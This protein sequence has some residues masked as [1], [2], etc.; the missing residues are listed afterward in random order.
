MEYLQGVAKTSRKRFKRSTH[1]IEAAL[2]ITYVGHEGHKGPV[3]CVESSEDC[4]WLCTGGED[5][6]VRVWHFDLRLQCYRLYACLQ[7]GAVV[8]SVSFIGNVGPV[9]SVTEK[10]F[11]HVWSLHAHPNEQSTLQVSNGEP[12]TDSCAWLSEASPALARQPPQKQR[13][14]LMPPLSRASAMVVWA[15]CSYGRQA[16]VVEVYAEGSDRVND[17][18]NHFFEEKCI[19]LHDTNVERVKHIPRDKKDEHTTIVTSVPNYI[20]LWNMHGELCDKLTSPDSS[21]PITCFTVSPVNND[22]DRTLWIIAGAG[23][24]QPGKV[25]LWA[26]WHGRLVDLN[27]Q[28]VSHKTSPAPIA[29]YEIPDGIV[30][31]AI[32]PDGVF[33]VVV[34]PH[35]GMDIVEIK[36]RDPSEAISPNHPGCKMRQQGR[37]T[38]Q[39]Y[40]AINDRHRDIVAKRDSHSNDAV[41][42]V[43]Y[44]DGSCQLW[45]L[46]GDDAG[47]KFAT[48]R[49]LKTKDRIKPVALHMINFLQ[50]TSFGFSHVTKW[51]HHV[52]EAA[53][54]VKGMS[55]FDLP[56][57]SDFCERIGLEICSVPQDVVYIHTLVAV[58]C[59][60]M[61]F[62]LFAVLG[63]PELLH[64]A[65]TSCTHTK[66]YKE[67][68]EKKSTGC[69]HIGVLILRGI[70]TAVALLMGTSSTVLVVSTFT[71]C[72][73]WFDCI[74]VDGIHDGELF[75]AA[76]PSFRCYVG[77]HR[78]VSIAL[79]VV[80]P[81][82]LILIIPLAA[83]WGDV[84]YVQRKTLCSP[85]AWRHNALRKAT[86]MYLGYLH[87]NQDFIFTTR[88][89]ELACKIMLPVMSILLLHQ[90][91]TMM[92]SIALV[93]AVMFWASMVRPPYVDQSWCAIVQGAKLFASC[94]LTCGFLSVLLHDASQ[95]ESIATL[96]LLPSAVITVIF[97]SYKIQTHNGGHDSACREVR[98][99]A[100]CGCAPYE[101]MP[102]ADAFTPRE[103]WSS[104]VSDNMALDHDPNIANVDPAYIPLSANV[105][106]DV[107]TA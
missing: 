68:V 30:D 94:V 95:C 70:K 91:R 102:V 46:E 1:E 107:E 77:V 11:L 48:V 40:V 93:G 27:D 76:A 47:E 56:V 106:G 17:A 2:G 15:V 101:P 13:A 34:A 71:A 69:A 31:V 60:M 64:Q 8:T 57:V 18:S 41:L 42:V 10:G 36:P 38:S 43:G 33:L 66:K 24:E 78:Q 79:A 52:A 51:E 104:L 61:L 87:P 81:I 19:L 80:I 92:G 85:P 12:I 44:D 50:V 4:D 7:Q 98:F 99:C 5:K 55:R 90:P 29:Q 86:L 14:G 54:L 28:P 9:V 97:I 20:Y 53:E 74:S 23:K 16:K 89:M 22:K 49:S 45:D 96:L 83:V 105:Q 39:V 82:Y 21:M 75:V 32:D 59:G 65:I 26:M 63:V 3:S 25:Y 35:G 72:A 37:E 67:E 58:I 100:G 6:T 84:A 73:K 62:I 88:L 103:Q